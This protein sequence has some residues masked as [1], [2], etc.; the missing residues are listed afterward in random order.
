MSLSGD[1]HWTSCRIGC[2]NILFVSLVSEEI[3]GFT[4]PLLASP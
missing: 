1:E 4:L 2:V 3:D